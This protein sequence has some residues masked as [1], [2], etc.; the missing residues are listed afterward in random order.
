MARLEAVR[1][2]A[3]AAASAFRRLRYLE[4]DP[5]ARMAW[6]AGR[7]LPLTAVE[8]DLL[9]LPTR[10]A[11]RTVTRDGLL[12]AVYGP[13]ILADCNALN[14]FM[15]RLRRK[16]AAAGGGYPIETVA[17]IGYKFDLNQLY[18]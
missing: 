5:S 16:L 18:T 13:D 14:V 9:E 1:R 6:A 7:E 4:I 10:H 12:E 11:G 3:L 15:S 8:F 2:R 17:R